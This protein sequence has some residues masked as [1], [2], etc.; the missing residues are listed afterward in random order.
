MIRVKICGI[1][2]KEDINLC[3][4]AGAD[5]LGFVVEYPIPVPWN[6]KRR[7]ARRLMES[8]PPFVSKVAVLGDDPDEVLSIADFLDPNVI[9]LHGEESLNFTEKLIFELKSRG[10]KVIKALRFAANTGKLKSDIP[11]PVAICERLADAGIDAVVLDSVTK[12]KPAGTGSTFDWKVARRVRDSVPIPVIL[13][14]GLNAGN[15]CKAVSDVRPY[16]VDVISGVENPVGKKDPAR[17]H[18]FL[19][20]AHRVA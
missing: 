10:I 4:S 18:A 12:S 2:N 19:M 7:T 13:A 16:G 20:A 14:G 17:V 15:V 9:Q 3:I 11:D 6:L 5:A 1:T 8:V